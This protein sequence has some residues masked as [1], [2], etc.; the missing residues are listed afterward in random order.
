VFRVKSKITF[1][2]VVV[3]DEDE[4]E[5]DGMKRPSEIIRD[6][7][8]TTIGRTAWLDDASLSFWLYAPSEVS[9]SQNQCL[10]TPCSVLRC[11]GVQFEEEAPEH[12]PFIK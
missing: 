4:E 2:M 12:F 9:P 3:G 6:I 11:P 7:C 10:L 1:I 8:S 5:D